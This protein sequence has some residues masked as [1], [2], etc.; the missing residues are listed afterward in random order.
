[1]LCLKGLE[2][3]CIRARLSRSTHKLFRQLK[4]AIMINPCFGDDETR[5]GPGN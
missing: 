1:M 5:L 4:A 3:N 2:L